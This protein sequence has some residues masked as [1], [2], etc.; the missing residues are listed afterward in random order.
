MVERQMLKG[1]NGARRLLA[2]TGHTRL[3]QSWR[4]KFA[5]LILL[6][7][8][9]SI[10]GSTRPGNVTVMRAWSLSRWVA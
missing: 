3:S 9:G 5:L 4:V 1:R 7:G 8:G 10:G 2:G 6:W